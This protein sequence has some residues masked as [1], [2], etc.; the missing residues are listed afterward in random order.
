MNGTEVRLDHERML[1]LLSS[2]AQLLTAAT[3]DV[4]ADTPVHNAAGRTLGQTVRQLGDLCEDVLCWLGSPEA[5]RRWDLPAEPELPEAVGRF[6]VRLAEVLAEFA[7]R[8]PESRCPTWWPED[9]TVRFWVRRLLHAVTLHRVDVQVAARVEVTEID[10]EVAADGVDEVLRVW[11][12]HRLRALGITATRACSVGV[13]VPGR[14]WL[15]TADEEGTAVLGSEDVASTTPDAV[16]SG[17]PAAV[18]L[19]AWGRLPNR[20]IE[21]TGDQ[22]AIAQLWG[23]LQLATR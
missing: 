21:T 3:H 22:D 10:P 18:Y 7:A 15:V 11:F 5:E 20:A 17:D 19:W 8:P 12:D 9:H 13:H 2:E 1:D 4:D 14:N 23:L 6:S 16:V